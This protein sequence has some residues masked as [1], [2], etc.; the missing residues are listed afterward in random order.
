MH[1]FPEAKRGL[2]NELPHT[3]AIL[4]SSVFKETLELTTTSRL[5]FLKKILD[6]L[7]ACRE[8]DAALF[9]KDPVGGI[10]SV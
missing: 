1:E 3:D 7:L 9:E 8:I 10:Q 6:P 2:P 4:F 5:Y